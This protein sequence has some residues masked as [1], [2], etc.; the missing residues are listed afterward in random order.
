[1]V[2]LEL[3]EVA[4][5][6]RQLLF[7]VGLDPWEVLEGAFNRS[8]RLVGLDDLQDGVERVARSYAGFLHSP[9]AASSPFGRTNSGCRI[10]NRAVFLT[11]GREITFGLP[12]LAKIATVGL[13][14]PSLGSAKRCRDSELGTEGRWLRGD[15]PTRSGYSGSC[16]LR[17]C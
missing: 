17:G 5:G 8:D 9:A 11:L 7:E 3:V 15:R 6:F 12:N 13:K 1:M 16:S 2:F 14:K 10:D 4:L